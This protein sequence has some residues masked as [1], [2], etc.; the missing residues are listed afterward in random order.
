M[1]TMEFLIVKK[2]EC[3]I[4]GKVVNFTSGNF[5]LCNHC[6]QKI[7]YDICPECAEKNVLECP[8]CH[9]TDISSEFIGCMLRGDEKFSNGKPEQ[10][11]IIRT[12]PQKTVKK[13]AVTSRTTTNT[14]SIAGSIQ[15]ADFQM[16][17]IAKLMEAMGSSKRD[18][19]LKSP[20][21]SG[22]TIILTHFMD[23]YCKSYCNTVFVWLTPGKG[24]LEEQSKAK[25]DK[26]IHNAQTKLLADVM[27]SGFSEN[28]C[29]FINWEKL[30]KSGN[31]ALKEGERKNFLEHI[32]AALDN[33]LQF[34]IIV[35]ESHQN[36]SVKAN[37]ILQYFHTD[38]II[39][40]SATPK[41]ITDATV[42]EVDEAEVIAAGLIKKLI[43]INEDFPQ[44]IKV[45]DDVDFLLERALAK[46]QELK[47]EFLQQKSNVNP[48]II[49][50]LP[51]STKGELL[52]DEVE[53]WFENHHI[54][55]ENGLLAVRLSDNKEGAIKR[56]ENLENIEDVDAKP[57]A[58]IIKQAVATGWDCPRAHILVK[59]RHKMDEKF[60]IQTIGRIRRMPEAKHYENDLL[61]RCYLYTLDLEFTDGMLK[62][63]GKGAL[64]A[65]KL[66]L[67]KEHKTFILQGEYKS[68]LTTT[69]RN[70]RQALDAISDYFNKTYYTDKKY[71]QNKSRL[72][73]EGYVFY[74]DVVRRT[75]SGSVT[76]MSKV[77]LSDLN[78]ISIRETLNTHKH[79]REFHHEISDIG[80]KIGLEYDQMNTIVRRL[81]SDTEK[82]KSRILELNIRQLYAFILNNADKLR[83]DIQQA[84][85]YHSQQLTIPVANQITPYTF[86]IPQETLFTYDAK[87]KSQSVMT[88]NVYKGYLSSAEPRSDSER[89]FEKYCESSKSVKW[90]YK[91]G[92]K[93][94][95][96][97]SIVYTDNSGKLKSF[98]PDYIIGLENGETW[99]IETKGGF[100]RTGKSEDIDIFSPK[101]FEVLKK[102]L[103]KHKLHG[104][105]VRK[106]K[107][108]QELCICTDNYSDN[109]Q[110]KDW[111]L[112]KKVLP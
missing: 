34:K 106:D 107:Q 104:G 8:V 108:S 88:K 54:T 105:F 30:T 67:K 68:A 27:T 47:A 20:T 87:A 82:D 56:K 74:D 33:G 29:C 38:K 31:N 76:K 63:M 94:S 84:M 42:I 2:S 109:I 60:E 83:H 70:S 103:Q 99:I 32:E 58:I 15:L 97:F 25:M 36:D 110:S 77:Q 53:R 16:K 79:G 96:Y 23:E 44:N 112:L 59:L 4:C 65:A 78:I 102:Y 111:K 7:T 18:I 35:D 6:R 45:S 12:M 41:D 37:D 95:E 11:A 46:Q 52:L 61:D 24:D 85:A 10:Q 72:E 71:K 98:Y 51:N 50:Q 28:D 22:K 21:G 3:R 80:L 17:A 19:V 43:V 40:A 1:N 9:S 90:W 92:D 62:S 49:I 91:N 13:S 86:R 89:V 66:Y 39:R 69:A 57:I 48:L 81:F 101:K 64:Y 26:Y 14:T 55:Y 100:D 73:A 5:Y 93:G 75:V